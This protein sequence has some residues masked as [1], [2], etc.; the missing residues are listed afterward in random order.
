LISYNTTGWK[1]SKLPYLC[2]LHEYHVIYSVRYYPR[3]HVTAVGLGTYYPWMRVYTCIRRF[4]VDV[5][6]LL[7]KKSRSDMGDK[8]L[9]SALNSLTLLLIFDF[10]FSLFRSNLL[11]VGRMELV[12]LTPTCLHMALRSG[13][14]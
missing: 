12:D 2:M 10:S 5:G 6:E 3:F 13:A 7:D 9:K 14:Q 8:F 11:P 1:L 4:R